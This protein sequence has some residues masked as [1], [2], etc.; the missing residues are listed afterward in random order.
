MEMMQY[1]NGIKPSW[2]P[3]CGD[4]SVLR[5]IQLA[6][7]RLKLPQK[8]LAIVGGI[9]CSGRLFAYM[10]AYAFHSVH[11]RSLPAAQGIKLA[12]RELTVLAVGGD[13]DGF[14]IGA[15]HTLHAI[16]RNLDITYIVMNNQLYGL[17]KGH[18][19]PASQQGLVTKSTPGGAND[20]PFQ[21]GLLAINAGSGFYAQGFSAE[22]EQLVD[23]IT[24]GML[25]KGFSLI[26]VFS[27]CITYNKM[28]TYAWFRENLQTVKEAGHENTSDY[29]SAVSMLLETS[30]LVTG[31]VY[32]NPEKPDYHENHGL[33]GQKPLSGI[34][35]TPTEK[36]FDRWTARFDIDR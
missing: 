24:E 27:P 11:G 35:L 3:G 29:M 36:Q 2:C 7:A 4:F 31:I 33:D 17:T 19:S 5:S 13:G 26:N 30:G 25:H 8:D 10:N 18:A 21:M 14:A 1:G 12:N 22:Q 16:R 28:N 15:G 23:L 6:A 20:P 32:Q 34:D 9:G